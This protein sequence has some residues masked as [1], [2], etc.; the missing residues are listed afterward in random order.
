[1]CLWSNSSCSACH[2][3]CGTLCSTARLSISTCQLWLGCIRTLLTLVLVLTCTAAVIHQYP[4]IAEDSPSNCG[5]HERL[6]SRRALLLADQLR[7]PLSAFPLDDFQSAFYIS[8]LVK[9]FKAQGLRNYAFAGFP[10]RSLL[11]APGTECA[12]WYFRDIWESTRDLDRIVNQTM[13]MLFQQVQQDVLDLAINQT[14]LVAH[15]LMSSHP[16]HQ[17]RTPTHDEL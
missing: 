17:S 16:T 11:V 14:A 8:V 6:H 7:P 3:F 1:M 15:A 12:V 2:C 10:P 13:T 5:A 4:S 9:G